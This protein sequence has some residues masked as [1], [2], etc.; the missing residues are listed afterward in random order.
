MEVEFMDLGG[1]DIGARI[2]TGNV[3]SLNVVSTYQ[4]TEAFSLSGKFGI[5]N[6]TL[7]S[8]GGMFKF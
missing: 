5:A 2:Y 3:L 4:F 6:T 8:V 1:F 7:S